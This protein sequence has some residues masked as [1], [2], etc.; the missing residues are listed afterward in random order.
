MYVQRIA[1]DAMPIIILHG[2]Y[3]DH[4]MW[5]NTISRIDDRSTVLLDMPWILADVLLQYSGMTIML[6]VALQRRSAVG[7][8]C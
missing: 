8:S 3:V 6:P 5:D 7:W 4:H 1:N 2:V